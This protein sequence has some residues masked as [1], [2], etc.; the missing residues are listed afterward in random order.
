MRRLP[1]FFVIDVSESMVGKPL[2]LMEDGLESIVSSLRQDPQAL[3]TV[4]ISIIAFAGKAKVLTPLIDLAS[5]YPPK[6]PIGGGT[7]LGAALDE[8]MSE[9]NQKI[10]QTTYEQKGDW[11]PIVFLITDGKP[12]DN[13]G[14][15]IDKWNKTYAKRATLVAITLGTDVD[16]QVLKSLTHD[17]FALENTSEGEFK[18][19]I[20]WLSNS[21]KAQ[22]QSLEGGTSNGESGISLAKHEDAGLT[23]IENP[24]NFSG[25]DPSVVVFTGRCSK[26]QLP[27]LIKYSRIDS[28]GK[29][30]YIKNE[31]FGLEGAYALDKTYGELSSDVV[32]GDVV[33]TD[34]LDGAPPCPQCGNATSFAMCQCGGLMCIGGPEDVTCPWCKEVIAFNVGSGSGSGFDVKRG[35]G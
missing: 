16:M 3:E 24:S 12:T 11:K 17:V 31:F 2:E 8:L 5:F 21:V 9:I 19:F 22:S 20:E 18:K 4:F 29:S 35:Q 13:P 7:Y 30:K 25:V 27:Y 34:M 1:I 10:N 26:K 28:E 6:I 15:S 14:I 32:V 33:S 23:L